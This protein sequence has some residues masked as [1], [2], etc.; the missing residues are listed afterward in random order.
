M[1]GTGKHLKNLR[2]PWKPGESGNPKGHPKGIR[3]WRTVFMEQFEKGAI[4][5]DAVC[6]SLVKKA[7]AG[8]YMAT[9]IIMDRMDGQPNQPL[10][11]EENDQSKLIAFDSLPPE[12]KREI[13]LEFVA[14]AEKEIAEAQ[15]PTVI[16]VT[17][18]EEK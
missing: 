10:S 9:K 4:S 7:A 2:P 11:L 18:K 15:A 16:D 5:Q 1:K 14:Q 12:L 8:D 3:T 13:A 17:P 6:L